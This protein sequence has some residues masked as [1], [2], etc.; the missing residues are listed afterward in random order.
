MKFSSP[1]FMLTPFGL[2]WAFFKQDF[3]TLRE[4]KGCLEKGGSDGDKEWIG[5]KIR[6]NW[7]SGLL[8]STKGKRGIRTINFFMN[9]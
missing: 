6:G 4:S 5:K 7:G 1:F 3:R 8:K 2:G 9:N